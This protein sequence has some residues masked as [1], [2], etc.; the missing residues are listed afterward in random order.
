M[1]VVVDDAWNFVATAGGGFVKNEF[2][3]L[4]A[5]ASRKLDTFMIVVVVMVMSKWKSIPK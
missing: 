4:A 2:D 3:F 5:N 1:V